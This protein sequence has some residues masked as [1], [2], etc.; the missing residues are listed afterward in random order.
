MRRSLLKNRQRVNRKLF[1]TLFGPV[2]DYSTGLEEE[3]LLERK[4]IEKNK[5]FVKI[6]KIR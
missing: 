6:T 5:Y 3:S 2:S 4:R 1:D